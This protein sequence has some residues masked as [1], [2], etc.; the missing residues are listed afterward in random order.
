MKEKI[1]Y[2][3]ICDNELK[4]RTIKEFHRAIVKGLINKYGAKNMK[5]IIRK[6]NL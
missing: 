1:D 5:E 4:E 3:F 6:I 2:N